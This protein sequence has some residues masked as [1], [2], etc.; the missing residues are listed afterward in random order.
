L[1]LGTLL[2]S[3]EIPMDFASDKFEGYKMPPLPPN[4]GKS[5]FVYFMKHMK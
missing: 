1:L 5:L 2:R 3:F 4:L